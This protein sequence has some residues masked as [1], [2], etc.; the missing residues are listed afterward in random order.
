MD[1]LLQCYLLNKNTFL[2]LLQK[3]TILLS[4]SS[5]LACYLKQEGIEPG[6]EPNDLDVWIS[7]TDREMEEKLVTFLQDSGYRMT[8]CHVE[9][10]QYVERLNGIQQVM[11]LELDSKKIQVIRLSSPR[12]LVNYVVNHFDFSVCMTWWNFEIMQFET[13]YSAL[14]LQKKMFVRRSFLSQIHSARLKERLQK[15]ISRG[16]TVVDEPPPFWTAPDPRTD[17]TLVLWRGVNGFD[18]FEY[19]DISVVEHLK[20]SEWNIVLGVGSVW[21][22]FERKRLC[23][24]MAEKRIIDPVWGTLYDTPFRQT[25]PHDAWDGLYYSDYSIFVLVSP[26]EHPFRGSTKTIYDVEAY[27]TLDWAQSVVS[28]IYDKRSQLR[29]IAEAGQEDVKEDGDAANP[30][31]DQEELDI[32]R[33]IGESLHLSAAD[34]LTD[35]DSDSDNEDLPVAPVAPVAPVPIP[36]IPVPSPLV[37]PPQ[38]N[39]EL[40]HQLMEWIQVDSSYM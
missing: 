9:N 21:Y 33:V 34:F 28:C 16:F 20:T 32:I 18:V 36:D 10:D 19:D 13:V 27:S 30:E 11:T 35:S 37:L 6:F 23:E 25:I 14:T 29:L 24:Y 17:E 2:E 8:H 7:S 4:G 38:V 31:F 12:S 39:Q 26:E 22:V 15:Y 40:W 3:E 1:A 5:A